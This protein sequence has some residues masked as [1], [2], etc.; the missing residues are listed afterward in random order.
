MIIKN[1]YN[2]GPLSIRIAGGE[3]R[4]AEIWIE[5]TCP[6]KAEFNEGREET[7]SYAS[8]EELLDL[9]DEINQA[10]KELTN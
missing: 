7:L 9:K 10:I 8:L 4:S 5:Q 6:K 2:N 3:N 1:G